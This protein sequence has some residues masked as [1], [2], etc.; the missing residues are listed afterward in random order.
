[1]VRD[2]SQAIIRF[3]IPANN[4]KTATLATTIPPYKKRM[5]I[6]YITLYTHDRKKAE[7]YFSLILKYSDETEL[8]PIMVTALIA[9][10][11]GFAEASQSKI[12]ARGLMQVM[13]FWKEAMEDESKG[14]WKGNKKDNLFDPRTNIRYGTRILRICLDRSKGNIKEALAR[15]NG[16]KGSSKYVNLVT[17][18]V[19]EIYGEFYDNAN[20]GAGLL[21]KI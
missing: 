15:Y 4:E 8:D 21:A 17:N 18:K 7:K 9:Q 12:G 11:S 14:K 2:S 16:S 1:M 19:A 10:E 5:A 13:P 6:D 3:K 20:G